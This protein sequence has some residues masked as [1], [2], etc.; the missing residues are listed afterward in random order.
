MEVLKI[1]LTVIFIIAALAIITIVLLQEGKS[2]GLGSIGGSASN[3][4]GS[5]WDKNKKHSLEGKFEKWTKIT[6][7]VFI[8]LGFVIMFL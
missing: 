3:A 8:A 6:A 2:A 1:I 5:Y 7:G 4:G